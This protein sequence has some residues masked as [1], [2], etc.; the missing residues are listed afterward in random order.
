MVIRGFTHSFKCL[1]KRYCFKF[2]ALVLEWSFTTTGLAVLTLTKHLLLPF[3]KFL[4]G[5][6][7]EACLPIVLAQLGGYSLDLRVL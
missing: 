1:F 6:L 4:Q 5:L 2:E 7:A 3:V